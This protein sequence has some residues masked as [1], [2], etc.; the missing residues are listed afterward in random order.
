MSSRI[1][2]GRR[3]CGGG[4]PNYT[5]KFGLPLFTLAKWR[6]WMSK[7]IDGAWSEGGG[8]GK[9]WSVGE[10]DQ[11]RRKEGIQITRVIRPVG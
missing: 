3:G 4:K 2:D 9:K 7:F 6:K 11:S 10:T 8:E 5:K 1:I